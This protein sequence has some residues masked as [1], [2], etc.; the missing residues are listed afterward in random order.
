MSGWLRNQSAGHRGTG[1]I[2]ANHRGVLLQKAA[3]PARA[4]AER[5]RRWSGHAA[6]TQARASLDNDHTLF[7]LKFIGVWGS[8]VGSVFP[9]VEGT[10][11]ALVGRIRD[12]AHCL[13]SDDRDHYSWL[14]VVPRA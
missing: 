9:F 11:D 10:G 12:P 6:R 7:I 8:I 1:I 5:E 13:Y 2:P 3:V 4:L 14:S